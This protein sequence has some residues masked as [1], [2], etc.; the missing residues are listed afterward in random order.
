MQVDFMILA[1]AAQ[2]AGGKL[3]I[4]GAGWDTIVAKQFPFVRQLAMAIGF[5][6]PWEETNER[7]DFELTIVP[8]YPPVINNPVMTTL[9]EQVGSELLGAE[10]V[11]E[12][13]RE[14]GG[15]DFG[16][17]ADRAPGCF[18]WLGGAFPGEPRRR[19]H[20]PLFDVDERCLP[21][22]TAVL[23]EAALRWLRDST[24]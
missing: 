20:H 1:D 5:L 14:M 10:N 19:H 16:Y 6:V 4:M 9:V 7:H 15:E 18:F 12:V 2:V 17:F 21:L 3:Y 22:G 11:Q 24:T 13:P 8:G 23:S